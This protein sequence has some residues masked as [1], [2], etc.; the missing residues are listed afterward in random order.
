MCSAPSLE[1]VLGRTSVHKLQGFNAGDPLHTSLTLSPTLKYL[2]ANSTLLLG[3]LVEIANTSNR[4]YI[5]YTATS[6][7]FWFPLQ[8]RPLKVYPPTYCHH[9]L[10]WSSGSK[11]RSHSWFLLLYSV[12]MISCLVHFRICSKSAH[13]PF[14]QGHCLAH[15][16]ITS[17][18]DCG[19]GLFRGLWVSF[20]GFPHSKLYM[21]VG[22]IFSKCKH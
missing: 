17:Y 18:T 10:P 7:L 6:T 21:A 8:S 20:L 3:C 2:T 16:D 14:P 12:I 13:C 19:L 9:H 5:P 11:L 22:G 1:S 15:V 4:K